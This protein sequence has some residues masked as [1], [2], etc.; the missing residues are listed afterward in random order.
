MI[1][2]M[3]DDVSPNVGEYLEI[4]GD[5]KGAILIHKEVSGV[6]SDQNSYLII[7]MWFK[8]SITRPVEFVVWTLTANT[9]RYI[10]E[11]GNYCQNIT[12]AVTQL[13]RRA[14]RNAG[15]EW[16]NV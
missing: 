11:A 13:N 8:N 9:E 7:A 5:P 14:G 16:L 6:C 10:V 3:V 12:E 2:P 15:D 4:N 1:N